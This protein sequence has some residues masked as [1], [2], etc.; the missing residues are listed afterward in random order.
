[1][2]TAI[3]VSP[4]V[5]AAVSA[6]EVDISRFEPAPSAGTARSV[7]VE[8]FQTASSSSSP[9]R[10]AFSADREA[11]WY[12]EAVKQ[13]LSRSAPHPCSRIADR[14]SVDAVHS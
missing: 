10:L 4:L 1:M 13:A 8:L 5:S 11:E 3:V 12:K 9:A 14:R 6:N 7:T 2:T